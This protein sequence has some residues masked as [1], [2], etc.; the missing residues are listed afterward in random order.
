MQV[1]VT[2]I[3]GFVYRL[4]STILHH[5]ELSLNQMQA[6]LDRD[7]LI[8]L[9]ISALFSLFVYWFT[10]KVSQKKLWT[11]C[12]FSKPRTVIIL[13]SVLLGISFNLLFIMFDLETS[14]DRLFPDYSQ[15]IE[16]LMSG[17]F[18][19]TLIIAGIIIPIFEE[20]LFR[21]IV[22]NR[23]KASLSMTAALWIQGFLFG[24]YH[25]NIF[26]G[27]YGM[28]LGFIAALVYEWFQ[29]LWVPIA[30]HVAFNSFSILIS[31]LNNLESI[32]RYGLF[33]LIGSGIL[34]GSTLLILWI[35]HRL[36]RTHSPIC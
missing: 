33:L 5:H 25:M 6:M 10:F 29:S 4:Q 22:F 3:Q 35:Y 8:M 23:L 7:V 34:L 26:Q 11:Y 9:I 13:L 36:T 20:I 16:P 18:G 32:L 21:G 24:V 14:F 1:L 12:K 15:A 17:G 30:V 27:I 2:M 31:R 19:L 28:I